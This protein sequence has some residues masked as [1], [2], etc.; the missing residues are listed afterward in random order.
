M[1]DMIMNDARERI[2]NDDYDRTKQSK[3][4]ADCTVPV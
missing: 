3:T 1:I 2:N 4:V